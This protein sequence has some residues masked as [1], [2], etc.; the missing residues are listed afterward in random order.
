MSDLAAERHALRAGFDADAEAYQRTRPV[1]PPR[2]FDDLVRLARLSAGDRVVEIGCGTGQA[3]VPLAERGL[4]VTAVELGASLAAAARRRLT[5]F[6]SVR[7]VTGSFEDWHEDQQRGD[8]QRGDQQ[9]GDQQRGDQQRGGQQGPWHAVVAFNSLHWIDPAVRYAKPARLLDGGGAMAVGGCHWARPTD[10]EPFWADVQ[11]DYRAVGFAGS[12]PPPPERIEAWH[13]P[14]E[15]SP[16]F[17]EIASLRYPFQM[18]YSAGDYLAQLATQSGTRALGAQRAEQ[19][20]SLVRR[21]LETA[22]WPPLTA[23]FVG[24][25]TVGIR[26]P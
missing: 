9:R 7:V 17:E 26:R 16:Y 4:A 14:A 13:F 6:P 5:A 3:T 1:C 18:T 23:T 20:L 8:Q 19:F 22:G 11:E 12:P 2:M 21:R 15:A 25:L 24:R 10:A